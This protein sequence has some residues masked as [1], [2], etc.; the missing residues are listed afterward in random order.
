MMDSL[1]QQFYPRM[2]QEGRDRKVSDSHR[3]GYYCPICENGLITDDVITDQDFHQQ[4]P[5]SRSN[6][7][8]NTYSN[9]AFSSA[10]EIIPLLCLIP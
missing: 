4:C 8:N 1:R 2:R 3:K 5:L 9:P 7:R 10:K 6:N